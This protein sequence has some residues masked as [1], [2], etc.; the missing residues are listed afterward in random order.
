M[1]SVN[2]Y[3][4]EKFKISKTSI[5]NNF[6][7]KDIVKQYLEKDLH[8]AEDKTFRL[9]LDTKNIK[10]NFYYIIIDFSIDNFFREDFARKHLC[11]QIIEKIKDRFDKD[12][13]I[14]GDAT[15]S[16][17]IQLKINL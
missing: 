12:I 10:D 14:E 5:T 13:K 17:I 4:L 2:E 3:I 7:I 15:S 9:K 16:Q 6:L 11:K 1:K 8:Y